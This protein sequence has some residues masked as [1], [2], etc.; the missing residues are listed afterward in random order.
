MSTVDKALA[1]VSD[2]LHRFNY[3]LYEPIAEGP[4]AI[5]YRVV[6]FNVGRELA[7]KL[8]RPGV[9][10]DPDVEE[11]FWEGQKQRIAMPHPR[12]MTVAQIDT[13]ARWIMTELASRSLEP[14]PGER[15]PAIDRARTLIWEACEGLAYL[16]DAGRIHG[17]ARL[18]NL[19][20]DRDLRLKVD[21]ALALPVDERSRT[22]AA[23]NLQVIAQRIAR[24]E[25]ETVPD[26][27]I[28]C[29]APELH[30]PGLGPVG[31]QS[32]VYT[33]GF[34]F[35]WWI[36]GP[37]FLKL[38]PGVIDS[39][40][41][42]LAWVRWHRSTAQLPP[43]TELISDIPEDL[44]LTL[45][46]MTR[47]RVDER[48]A[49]ASQALA[50]LRQHG[51]EP[52]TGRRKA[53]TS[54][55][56]V[57]QTMGAPAIAKAPSYRSGSLGEPIHLNRRQ[58]D[59]FSE[60]H[61]ARD[62]SNDWRD[63]LRDLAE[64]HPKAVRLVGGFVTLLVLLVML[65]MIFG[66]GGE[67][68]VEV[69]TNIP[70]ADVIRNGRPTGLQTPASLKLAPGAYSIAFELKGYRRTSDDRVEVPA[71]V[72]PLRLKPYTLELVTRM[73]RF[74]TMPTGASAKFDDK[75]P[76]ASTPAFVSLAPGRRK[77]RLEKPGFHS[78][79]LEVDCPEGDGVLELG[80]FSLVPKERTVRLIADPTE[81]LLAIDG[82]EL[83]ATSPAEEPL[84][85]GAHRLSAHL[86]G[87][88]A[89]E[90][91]I[92][93]EPGDDVQIA[94][95]MRLAPVKQSIG[96]RVTSDPGS[97][98]VTVKRTGASSPEHS[99]VTPGE[100]KLDPSSSWIF[101]AVLP[102]RRPMI[103]EVTPGSTE[104]VHF[105]LNPPKV[106]RLKCGVE[107]AWIP[108]GE[109][110]MGRD[111]PPVPKPRR[112]EPSG[113]TSG[114]TP[115]L[116][117]GTLS[118]TNIPT[119]NRYTNNINFKIRSSDENGRDESPR[120]T[121]RLQGYYVMRT[122]VTQGLYFEMM[123]ENP[124]RFRPGV[125]AGLGDTRL[126]P[127]ERVSYYQ[128]EEFARRLERAEGLPRGSLR[129]P[130]E[131]QWER[132]ATLRDNKHGAVLISSDEI[133]K[134]A[135]LA[136]N[137]G[138]KTRPVGRLD[139][140][141]SGCHDFFGNVEEWTADWYQPDYYAESPIDEPEGPTP[142]ANTRRKVIRGGSYAT[143]NASL[144]ATARRSCAPEDG[145][146]TIGFR[147]V[148]VPGSDYYEGLA[149]GSTI[150]R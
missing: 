147:L 69:T 30:N 74:D 108:E 93:V 31:P 140:D 106:I 16:H 107:L 130:S 114:G 75:G 139:R 121:V 6:D 117:L 94:P 92:T 40:D 42:Y 90:M 35:L 2:Q 88:I 19:M 143:P 61:T 134:Q 104:T 111:A 129:V 136:G 122:E 47:K 132:A 131:A 87:F 13:K 8:F 52:K 7:L 67:R 11:A 57:T 64:D 120:H 81:A 85:V 60:S 9:F 18:S 112:R 59:I 119:T 127:V 97:V 126:H 14:K 148:L 66:D 149:V 144:R 71:G 48:F 96:V 26:L 43:A 70:G 79:T 124:S 123:G 137:S 133:R 116:P 82:K 95:I 54:K 12:L 55:A 23:G 24:K 118:P 36:V 105:D 68:I 50:F 38:V 110:Q 62:D 142:T 146:P 46:R 17:G 63:R 83:G 34:S 113:L 33:I 3:G 1:H 115:V 135:W 109:F 53:K 125:V 101:T 10:Y 20:L 103:R 98:M 128:A 89:Q 45:D 21:G 37:K 91:T 145:K 73:T 4:Q 27:A 51:G 65:G 100:V 32:D 102:G 78:R 80:T 25:N 56:N 77:L 84:T 76:A 5:I 99:L 29:H 28:A 138:G 15:P 22:V 58:M 86:N 41:P 49:D 141:Y 44:A 39:G 150:A 72:G